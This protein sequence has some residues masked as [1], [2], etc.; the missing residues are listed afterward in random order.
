MKLVIVS[1]TSVLSGIV[2]FCGSVFVLMHLGT[3]RFDNYEYYGQYPL[4]YVGPG[5]AGFVLPWVVYG[6]WRL[7]RPPK[8]SD[9]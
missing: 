7:F 2:C 3:R 1:M 8:R 6:V 5:I 4:L 9:A